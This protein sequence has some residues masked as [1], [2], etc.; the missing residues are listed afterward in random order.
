M[1][2]STNVNNVLGS[3]GSD[4]RPSYKA[5]TQ[6]NN[7]QRTFLIRGVVVP[8]P[9]PHAVSEVRSLAGE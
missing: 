6:D 5:V 8:G 2:I 1:D 3:T 9:I 7:G 4:I